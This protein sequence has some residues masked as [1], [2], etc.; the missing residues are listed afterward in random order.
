MAILSGLGVAVLS[1]LAAA[2]PIAGQEAASGP[3]LRAALGGAVT[4]VYEGDA[5][6]GEITSLGLSAAASV[7]MRERLGLEVYFTRASLGARVEGT[8]SY[9][10]AVL[11]ALGPPI[12]GSGTALY[13]QGGV[14]WLRVDDVLDPDTCQP[15]CFAEGG[16][17]F[18]EGT[19]ASPVVGLGV[20]IGLSPSAFLRTGGRWHVTRS[21]LNAGLLFGLEVG[22]RW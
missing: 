18:Q 4:R 13:L 3:R 1:G 20:E 6:V 16:P 15:P 22:L 5:T 17:G 21:L 9:Y 7:R 14:G 12:R 19:S 11:D 2:T 8:L 10:G